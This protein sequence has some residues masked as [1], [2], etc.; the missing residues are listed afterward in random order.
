MTMTYTG[1]VTPG[2]APAVREL[3]DLTITQALGRPDGQQRLPAALRPGDQLLIDAANDAPPPAGPDRC[4]RPGHGGH[5][6][7]PQRPLAGA[8]RGGRGDRRA[9]A[10]PRRR[11]RRDPGGHRHAAATATRSRSATATLEVIHMVGH[12]PG[13]IALLYQRPGR[14]RPP[15]HRRLPLPRRRRQHPRRPEGLRV[16]DR[17][18]RARSSSTASP[19]TPGSTPATARTPPWARSARRRVA[20][21]RLVVRGRR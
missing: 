7:P 11:R 14:H 3:A 12:T 18:R 15:V 5:H 16:P 6:P 10:G 9:S 4:G 2:G 1:D 21:P 8:G 17:R 13:S 20:R 19:T